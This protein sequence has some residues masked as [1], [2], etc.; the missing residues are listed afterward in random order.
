[1]SALPNLNYRRAN[2]RPTL[3]LANLAVGKQAHPLVAVAL[4]VIAGFVAIAVL[5]LILFV[6]T[7]GNQYHLAQLKNER[8]QVVETTQIL[9]QQ[10]DSLSSNQNLSNAAQA[11]G[12]ISNSTPVYLTLATQTTIGKPKVALRDTASRVSGNLV[13]NL[14]MNTKTNVAKLRAALAQQEREAT[15]VVHNAAVKSSTL[16]AGQTQKTGTIPGVDFGAA[17]GNG[18]VANDQS[19]TA[20]VSSLQGQIPTSPTH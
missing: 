6:V 16:Q 12:M 14:A 20:K 2:A 5:N 10:V 19:T 7:S 9:Q 8:D 3:Q 17:A 4:I 13:S 1:M 11:L 15:R 18:N